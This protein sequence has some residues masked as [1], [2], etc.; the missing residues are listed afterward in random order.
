MRKIFP[1]NELARDERFVRTKIEDRVF[2]PRNAAM[3]E[4]D[5]GSAK[6]ERADLS[7]ECR[8]AL[9]LQGVTD[10]APQ[11]IGLQLIFYEV[12]R[13]AGLHCLQIDFMFPGASE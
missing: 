6:L 7:S 5:L 1:P 8:G 4:R 11:G 2:D 10:A 9:S 3:I 13:R 12:I